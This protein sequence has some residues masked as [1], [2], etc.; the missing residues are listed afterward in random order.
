MWV[1]DVVEVGPS[2]A[3]AGGTAQTFIVQCGYADHFLEMLGVF[4]ADAEWKIFCITMQ[5][6]AAGINAEVLN[7]VLPNDV[8]DDVDEIAFAECTE[9][10]EYR[11]LRDKDVG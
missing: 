10:E 7:P 8:G 3:I 6:V 2:A 4:E 1:D 11:L 5:D 9:V